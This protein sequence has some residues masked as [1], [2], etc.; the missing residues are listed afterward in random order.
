MELG[1]VLTP[2]LPFRDR[3][4]FIRGLFNAEALKGNIH[5]SQTGNLLSGA[6]LSAGGTIR[7]GTSVDQVIA[8]QIGHQ[9]KLPT[10]HVES[11]KHISDIP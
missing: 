6:P 7:S 1:Q 8:Q 11:I 2:L 3:M 10:R 5:S 9:T 4:T